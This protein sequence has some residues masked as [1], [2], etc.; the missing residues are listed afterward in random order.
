MMEY[1][2]NN[3]KNDGLYWFLCLFMMGLDYYGPL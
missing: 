2:T 1:T 3:S